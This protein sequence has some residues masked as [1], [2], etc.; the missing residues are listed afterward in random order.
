MS[1]SNLTVTLTLHD[2]ADRGEACA[3]LPGPQAEPMR[4]PASSASL[5]YHLRQSQQVLADPSAL[6][7]NLDAA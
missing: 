7:P 1:S 4:N 5:T 6:E 3:N 2:V